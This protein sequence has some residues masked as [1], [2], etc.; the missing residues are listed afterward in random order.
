MNSE[1]L[2]VLYISK[3]GGIRY[4]IRVKKPSGGSQP[5]KLWG[6][7]IDFVEEEKKA[8]PDWF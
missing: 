1:D 3:W 8:V 2:W 5:A 6:V 4:E 7:P